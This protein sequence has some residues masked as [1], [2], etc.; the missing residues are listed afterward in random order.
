M[1]ARFG[2][3]FAFTALHFERTLFARQRFAPISNA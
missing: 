1:E 3:L 2:G